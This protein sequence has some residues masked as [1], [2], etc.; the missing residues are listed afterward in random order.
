MSPF[1]R[2]SR[3]TLPA[4]LVSLTAAL[5]LSGC[6]LGDQGLQETSLDSG[7][8]VEDFSRGT[9]SPALTTRNTI[10]IPGADPAANAAAAAI[11]VYPSSSSFTRPAAVTVVNE[12]DWREA[13]AMSVLSAPPLSAPLLLS[14]SDSM[15]DV[16]RSAMAAL[17]PSGV[18]IPGQTLRPKAFTAGTLELP[19]RT[20]RV[21]LVDDTYE[22]LSLAVDR[23]WTRLTGGKPSKQVIVTTADPN[24]KRYALPAGPLAAN[25]GS[26]VFFVNKDT[27]PLATLR[28]IQEHKKPSIYVVGPKFAISDQLL[29]VLRKYGTVRRIAGPNPTQNAV[30]VAT[31]SDPATDWGWGITDPGHGFVITNSHKEMNVAAATTL[32]AGAAYGPLLLNSNPSVVDRELRNYLL[33]EQSAYIDNPANAVYNRAWLLG[34]ESQFSAGIQATFDKLL[35]VTKLEPDGATGSTGGDGATAPAP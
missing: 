18:V 15:P 8:S 22:N 9:G 29:A 24:L 1:L 10:R 30:E 5:A 35:A 26:P 20:P 3:R 17:N 19:D 2:Q 28:A 4:A 7:T 14:G 13:I 21:N 27:V 32:S 34:D 6:T 16:T 25:T 12:N 33:D 31:F 11:T 23:L